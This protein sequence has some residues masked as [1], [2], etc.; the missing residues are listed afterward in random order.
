MCVNVTIWHNKMGKWKEVFIMSM[1][2]INR[3]LFSTNAKDIGLLYIIL[4]ILSGLLGTGLSIIIR[5]E[6]GGPGTQY[7]SDGQVYNVVITSHAI[8]M[9]FFAVMPI[10]IGGFGNILVPI[11]IGTVDMSFPRLNNIS[12]W[13]LPGSLILLIL[14]SLMD[15]GV[16]TG[17]TLYP[18]LSSIGYHS[19][20]SV[21]LGILALHLSGLSS[22]M[23]AINLI[24]TIINM[25]CP[26]LEYHK[27]PLFVW[28][29]LIT[30]VLLLLS[31]PVLA[32]A[33]TLLLLDRNYNT[34]FYDST[35]G[36]DPIIYQH[37][38]WSTIT[39]SRLLS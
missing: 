9:I 26:G 16:G 21:D 7:I 8:L 20:M 30:G 25:R 4:G 18:P 13:L 34:S 15:E 24:T 33:I 1:N 32:G 31:L 12:F 3:W 23:G 22:L 14:S 35:G 29:I 27:L 28:S 5:M 17:W 39:L 2:W 6:L 19:G 10:L 37:L 36:G 11:M 38:F